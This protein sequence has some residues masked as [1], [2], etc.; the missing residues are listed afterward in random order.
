MPS[1]VRAWG[2]QLMNS[3]VLILPL[4]N[5]R[6]RLGSLMFI[7]CRRRLS[8]EGYPKI[9]LKS[10]SLGDSSPLSFLLRAFALKVVWH[11]A[12]QSA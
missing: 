1:M 9:V 7:V 6:L 5:I 11:L 8:F 10:F 2:V 3:I 4:I 12:R